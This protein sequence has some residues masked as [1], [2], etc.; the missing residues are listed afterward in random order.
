MH[1]AEWSFSPRPG[2]ALPRLTHV[3][4]PGFPA[5]GLVHLSG[6]ARPL[7]WPPSCPQSP[8]QLPPAAGTLQCSS[9]RLESSSLCLHDSLCPSRAG[10]SAPVSPGGQSP[11][12]CS[13]P[14][15][16]T[17]PRST[18]SRPSP[19]PTRMLCLRSVSAC[20]NP[21]EGGTLLSLLLRPQ[22]L[23]QCLVRS[24]YW[25]VSLVEE[26][27]GGEVSVPALPFPLAHTRS[28]AWP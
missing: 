12:K 27:T 15:E 28:P 6:P 22:L 14:G 20:Q 5:R 4:K 19:P 24:R 3:Q 16:I 2:A 25:T 1:P 10:L 9:L 23:E 7:R 11:A 21:Q 26:M 17:V 13:P 18:A 8:P